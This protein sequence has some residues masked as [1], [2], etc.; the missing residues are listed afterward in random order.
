MITYR[1]SS[2]LAYSSNIVKNEMKMRPKR[3]VEERKIRRKY[4]SIG[5][6]L[7]YVQR[8]RYEYGIEEELEQLNG[9]EGE[10]GERRYQEEERLL[11]GISDR[12]RGFT[13]ERGRIRRRRLGIGYRTRIPGRFRHESRKRRRFVLRTNRGRWRR[14]ENWYKSEVDVRRSDRRR[15]RGRYIVFI[16]RRW[17]FIQK[18]KLEEKRRESRGR[19]VWLGRRRSVWRSEERLDRSTRRSRGRTRRCCHRRVER[20]RIGRYRRKG[21][22][23][24]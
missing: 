13:R 5:R 1:A 21:R 15:N 23:R 6:R 18:N 8:K 4:G 9:K 14:R 20:R 12:G 22:K 24:K 10:Y 2:S 19:R 3:Y 17:I 16:W 7:G 11:K